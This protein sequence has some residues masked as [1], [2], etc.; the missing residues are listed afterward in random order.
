MIEKIKHWLINFLGLLP[1]EGIDQLL[2]AKIE[3]VVVQLFQDLITDGITQSSWNEYSKNKFKAI[4]KQYYTELMVGDVTM[5]FEEA[6]K[7]FLI[8]VA[9]ERLISEDFLKRLSEDQLIT[10]VKLI[11]KITA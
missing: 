6:K 9:P 1:P 7:Q 4:L 10:L 5:V 2:D 8:E 3:K 11:S